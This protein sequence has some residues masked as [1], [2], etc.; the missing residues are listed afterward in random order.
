MPMLRAHTETDREQD[1]QLPRDNHAVRQESTE[2]RALDLT[3][4]SYLWI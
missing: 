2:E 4:V 3:T 1:L